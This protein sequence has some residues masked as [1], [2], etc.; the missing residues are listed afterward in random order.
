LFINGVFAPHVLGDSRVENALLA[1]TDR[2][3]D[4]VRPSDILHAAI[5]GRDAK[6]QGCLARAMRDGAKL[7]A[8]REIIEIFNPAAPDDTDFDGSRGRFSAHA[9]AALDA[10]GGEVASAPGLS[11]EVYLEL[12]LASVLAHLDPEELEELTPLDAELGVTVLRQQVRVVAEPLGPLFDRASGRV[13][14]EEFT[15]AAW[16][17]VEHAAVQA[18]ELGYDRVLPPHCF[19]ALLGETEGLAEHLVRLQ[20]APDVSPSKVAGAVTEAFRLG[21]RRLAAL[22]ATRD[23]FG[24]SF[25]SMLRAAQRVAV[26]WGADQIDA[27]HLLAALLDEMPP[28]LA[29]ILQRHPVNLDLATMR[30]HLE[31]AL[32]DQRTRPPRES[33]FRLPP[34]LPPNEDLTALARTSGIDAAL[35]LDGYFDALTRALYRKTNNHVLITGLR[36]V[37]TTTLVRELARRA[38]AGEIPF[39]A[40]RRFLWVDG[41]DVSPAA[42]ADVL[43]AIVA[44]V[45]GR[46]D[47]V[48][49]LD[50]LG[51]LLRA[52]SGADHKVLLRGV[53]KDRRVQLVG[54]MESH[55]YEDLVSADYALLE[56]LTRI[57]VTEPEPAAAVAMAG[58]GAAA[59]AEAFNVSIEP[60]AVERA[61]LISADSILNERLPAKAVKVLRR[62]CEDLDYERSQ[63]GGSR[64]TVGSDDV[65]R[66]IAEITGIPAEQL[67]GSGSPGGTIDY[68]K[69]LGETIHGQRAAV[70]AV[71]AQLRRIKAGMTEPGKPASVLFFAG[72]TGVGKTELAK[73]IASFY[74]ASKRLQTYSMANY[75]EEHSVS[76][77]TG[78][79]PGYVGY[80]RG[81]RLI[82]DLNADPYCVFLLDEAEK[83]HP[84][85]WKPFLNLFDEAWVTDLRGVKAFGDR[86]IFIL[87]SNAGHEIISRM[88]GRQPMADVVAAV[89]AGLSQHIHPRSREPVFPP[90]FLARISE[91][92]VFEPL[93]RDAMAGICRKM[94]D[95]KRLT[96]LEKRGKRLVVPDALAT[97]IVEL[98]HAANAESGGKEGGRIVAKLIGRLVDDALARALAE[99]PDAY[100]E[101]DVVELRLRPPGA[102][103]P[104]TP[105]LNGLRPT[106]ASAATEPEV[107]VVLHGS[108]PA[109]GPAGPAGGDE[110]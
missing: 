17:V 73:A 18:T 8:V 76:A 107:E 34:G 1:A 87:T 44:Q 21:A 82:N 24:D 23:D 59:L 108:G 51:P 19:L 43:A 27:A 5:A 4:R 38:A 40:R 80:E 89:R 93:D 2:A 36:G 68:E 33:V 70:A 75:T 47:L 96:W 9:L 71:A 79:P 49:C 35:H 14:S 20:A 6:I 29:S 99:R 58:Q 61:V 45:A 15:E 67:S 84:N 106:G 110:R 42:S 16:A 81:G 74:S 13:R 85:V 56:L 77:I 39:L 91:I 105:A 7:D 55:D 97:R 3:A 31:Q 37:G 63:R 41:R 78:V 72:L 104:G 62:A 53:L 57:E 22:G 11:R 26:T 103:R 54:V 64:G 30:R 60:R 90:E 98:S 25:V 48:L 10:F 69:A 100:R 109:A 88:A 65:V 32:L 95:R 28:R 52:E 101:A 86:A 94:L 102:S 92:I 50:G 12:L 46:T 66:V 83:A